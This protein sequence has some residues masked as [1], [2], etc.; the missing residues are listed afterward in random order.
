MSGRTSLALLICGSLTGKLYAEHGDYSVVFTRFF[1]SSLPSGSN[2]DFILDPYY[3][4]KM[5]YPSDDQVDTYDAIV[6]TGSGT[7]DPRV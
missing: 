2:A 4:Q 7:H 5:E 1:Q 6:L 3:V